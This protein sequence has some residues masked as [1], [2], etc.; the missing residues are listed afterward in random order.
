MRGLS[1]SAISAPS[2]SAFS[3]SPNLA[4]FPAH[5]AAQLSG[6][7]AVAPIANSVSA[8]ITALALGS[9]LARACWSRCF[10]QASIT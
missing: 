2:L 1:S 5:L 10:A 9:C 6:Q 7:L 4:I 8:A 3:F